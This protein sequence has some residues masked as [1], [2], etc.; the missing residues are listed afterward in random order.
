[1]SGNLRRIDECGT[2]TWA[3]IV[4]LLMSADA[5]LGQ[6]SGLPRVLPEEFETRAA[7]SAA[8]ASVRERAGVWLLGPDGYAETRQSG[9][10]FN[11][12]VVREPGDEPGPPD[13]QGFAPMC[14]DAEGS[15]TL[16]RRYVDESRWIRAEGRGLDEVA[17]ALAADEARYTPERPGITY[18]ASA[19]NTQPDPTAPSG[20]FRAYHPH[21]MFLAPGLSDA[22]VNGGR[23]A[24]DPGRAFYDGWPFLP[25]APRFD[26]FVVVPLDRRLRMQ[27]VD[28]QAELLRSLARYLPRRESV[29][30]GGP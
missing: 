24:A 8:P 21:V 7:L 14:F 20:P 9:N 19:L 6:P 15:R 13:R 5:A 11:C 3:V 30:L 28:E 17:R 29:D 23:I 27:I 2:T 16:L 22:D 18:M 26:G 10:G 1:M 12:L 25:G 4:T